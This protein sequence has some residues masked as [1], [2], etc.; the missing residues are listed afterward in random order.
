MKGVFCSD[1]TATPPGNHCTISLFFRRRGERRLN[2]E[3]P[4]CLR[5][6]RRKEKRE[7]Q[8]SH[9][10]SRHPQ[11]GWKEEEEEPSP[12]LISSRAAELTQLVRH[13][14]CFVVATCKEK[15]KGENELPHFERLSYGRRRCDFSSPQSESAI[16]LSSWLYPLWCGHHCLLCNMGR[17]PPFSRMGA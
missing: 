14:V 15:G 10:R 8:Q 7:K 6:K 11:V 17:E 9:R 4:A 1:L 16:S 5:R 2:I 3:L 13:H 12:L